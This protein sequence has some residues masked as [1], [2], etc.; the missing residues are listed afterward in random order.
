MDI[1]TAALAYSSGIATSMFIIL[2]RE[3]LKRRERRIIAARKLIAFRGEFS[4]QLRS[5]DLEALVFDMQE[6]VSCQQHLDCFSHI[7]DDINELRR[8]F[9]K[10]KV[11]PREYSTHD[12]KSDNAPPPINTADCVA[13]RRELLV[14]VNEKNERD[15]SFYGA[16]S[17]LSIRCGNYRLLQIT[18]YR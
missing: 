7:R 17:A 16:K 18:F 12:L 9:L 6:L 5:G 2:L 11:I 14:E 8:L 10:A 15:L 3:F 4:F 13:M 1:F